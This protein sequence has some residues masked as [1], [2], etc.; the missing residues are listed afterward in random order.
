M[1]KALPLLNAIDLE[2]LMH[3]DSHFGG[4]FSIMLDYYSGKGVGIMPDFEVES[5]EKLQAI[6]EELG[7]DLAHKL[8]PPSAKDTVEAAK[9]LYLKLRSVYEKKK[10]N[11]KATLISDLIL[12]ES[13]DPQ[14]EIA[15]IVKAGTKMVQPLIDL[16][17][18]PDLYDPLYPGYGRS[19]ILIA[20]CLEQLQ[21]E[22]AIEPLFNALGHENFFTDEAL[23]KALSAFQEKATPFLL[24]ILQSKPLSKDNEHAAIA[25]SSFPHDKAIAQTCL[26]MLQEEDVLQRPSLAIYLIFSCHALSS[27]EDQEQFSA[28][29]E[30]EAVQVPLKEEITAILKSWNFEIKQKQT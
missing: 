10:Q 27:P 5:I 15:A 4:K 9:K 7:T 14:K 12:S 17:A 8:L 1:D 18:L 22:R 6:E 21:D 26:K 3:R 23:L 20:Q 30:K 29:L 28:L 13:E 24:K 2:I 25:L 19:P 16:L 11:T